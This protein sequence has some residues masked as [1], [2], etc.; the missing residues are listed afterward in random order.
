MDLSLND[1]IQYE[2]PPLFRHSHLRMKPKIGI[3]GQP[4]GGK[5]TLMA[6][7][8]MLDFM[9]QTEP[10]WSNIHVKYAF[11]ITDETASKYGLKGGQAT[12]EA[13][14]L[15]T[16]KMYRMD[17][18]YRRGLL[19]LDEI[20]VNIADAYKSQTNVNFY[21]DQVDQQLRKDENG[22]TYTSIHEMWVDPRVRDITDIMI[23]CK[24]TARTPEGLAARKKE[25]IDIE[26]WVY[27]MTD[28][29]TGHSYSETGEKLGPYYLHARQWW[30][31][32]D[33]FQKQATGQKYARDIFEKTT[34][35]EVGENQMAIE[36]Y[37]KWGWLYDK[38][39][40]LKDEGIN[41]ITSPELWQY[42]DIMSRGIDKFTIGRQLSKM[43]LTTRGRG[44]ADN[45]T[46]YVIP[47]F[48]LNKP[49]TT[50]QIVSV[51]R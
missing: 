46:K 3:F 8:N 36:E 6:I 29:L 35:L 40:D 11:D 39:R 2:L 26:F 32:F 38:V 21:F 50:R 30:G 24:D 16:Y 5:S 13:R 4:G 51:G 45:P 1:I 10:C 49:D 20:N 25:G 42:L 41:E 28:Y 9:V 27:P 15:D 33:T 34:P 23:K 37:S 7:I 48:D 47:D 44:T 18:E 43:G 12:Y 19:S 14:R 31:I 22:L 17:P